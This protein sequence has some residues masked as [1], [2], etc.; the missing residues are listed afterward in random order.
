MDL[1]RKVC[2]D[3]KIEIKAGKDGHGQLTG[4]AAVFG[5]IDRDGD[6]IAKGAFVEDLPWF[7]ENGFIAVG[8]NHGAL[9]VASISKAAEDDYGLLITADFHSTPEAQAARVTAQERIDR[10]K[11]VSLSIG[12]KPKVGGVE[13]VPEG[14]LLKKV[15]TFETS[16]VNIPANP[17]ALVTGVKDGLA[18]GLEFTDHLEAVADAAQEVVIRAKARH[19]LR[20]KAGR[21]L[22]AANR[23]KLSA[24]QASM[25]ELGGE[26]TRLL[27]E[28][29]PKAKE[30][31]ADEVGEGEETGTKS[32]R[33]G[34]V[35]TARLRVERG[36]MSL[37]ESGVAV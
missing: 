17:L 6:I 18:D 29:E 34:D 26:L 19:D 1:E 35:L 12:Y 10:G 23:E 3:A 20:V 33:H 13:Y 37:R 15:Q 24:L 11:S 21:V 4:Y 28:T 22:S 36:L 25:T 14:R 5:L 32:V 30:D 27:A 9:P 8:H 7:V 31:D 2:A 16:L